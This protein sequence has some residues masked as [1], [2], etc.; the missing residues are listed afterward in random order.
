[1]Y[2]TNL[3]NIGLTYDKKGGNEKA[4]EYY[5]NSLRIGNKIFE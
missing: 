1:M 4:L 3:C 2:A 5:L